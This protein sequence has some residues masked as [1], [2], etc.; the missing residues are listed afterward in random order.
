L[1]H[2]SQSTHSLI[3]FVYLPTY[4]FIQMYF[5]S[6]SLR[7]ANRHKCTLF[8]L[9]FY[10]KLSTWSTSKKKRRCYKSAKPYWPTTLKSASDHIPR[11]APWWNTVHSTVGVYFPNKVQSC[12]WH[13]RHYISGVC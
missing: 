11:V 10:F 1:L 5:P 8:T 9:L 6:L 2:I 3:Y 13:L 7:G 12:S 4:V